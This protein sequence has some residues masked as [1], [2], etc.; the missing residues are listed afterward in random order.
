MRL[1][2]QI[3][4]TVTYTELKRRNA[5]FPATQLMP[6]DFDLLHFRSRRWRT[7][8]EIWRDSLKSGDLAVAEPVH[9]IHLTDNTFFR[10][11]AGDYRDVVGHPCCQE[12]R[13]HWELVFGCGVQAATQK[14]VASLRHLVVWA[15]PPAL[16]GLHIEGLGG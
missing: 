10:D 9:A 15:L 4:P 12:V 14:R 13:Q 3:V 11:K 1:I 7:Q 16:G 5:A 6:Q 8:C 2:R